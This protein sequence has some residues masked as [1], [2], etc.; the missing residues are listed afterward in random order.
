VE[1]EQQLPVGGVSEPRVDLVD[2]DQFSVAFALPTRPLA[3]TV[4]EAVALARGSSRRHP[5]RRAARPPPAGTSH[6]AGARPLL[7]DARL[8]QVDLESL[9]CS[10]VTSTS[11]RVDAISSTLQ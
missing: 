5:R 4:L 1:G 8:E 7:V 9:I 6:R 10:F 3:P 2:P 11:S